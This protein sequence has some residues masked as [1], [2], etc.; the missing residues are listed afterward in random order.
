VSKSVHDEYYQNTNYWIDNNLLKQCIDN[1]KIK[2]IK[3]DVSDEITELS[4]RYPVLNEGE[5]SIMVIALLCQKNSKNYICVIDDKKAQTI[6]KRLKL[7]FIGSIGLI[8]TIKDN[9]IWNDET[10]DIIISDI[11]KSPFYVSDNILIVLKND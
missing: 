10:M 4:K 2:I 6:A 5:L 9:N 3:K 8:K 11:K 7:N 1:G